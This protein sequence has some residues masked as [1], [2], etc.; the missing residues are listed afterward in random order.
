[1]KRREKTNLIVVHS[2]T[3]RTN[4]Y[5]LIFDLRNNHYRLRTIENLLILSGPDFMSVIGYIKVQNN[6]EGATGHS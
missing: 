6:T 5:H 3:K 1:M 2:A 4:K